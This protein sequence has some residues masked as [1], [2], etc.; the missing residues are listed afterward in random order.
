VE[1]NLDWRSYFLVLLIVFHVEQFTLL[2][3]PMCTHNASNL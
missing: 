3:V 2:Y 1:H